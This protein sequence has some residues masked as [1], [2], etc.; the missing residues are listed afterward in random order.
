[1][2]AKTESS[3]TTMLRRR[4]AE[5]KREA[6]S[7]GLF[8]P[9]PDK[10]SLTMRGR[11]PGPL[12]RGLL[13]NRAVDRRPRQLLVTGFDA[14]YKEDVLTQLLVSIGRI[15]LILTPYSNCK[16]YRDEKSK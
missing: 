13:A 7:L 5:L 10:P 8:G 12:S 6:A 3:E 9:E 2:S 15:F 1:M 4:V 11:G 16:L 14:E